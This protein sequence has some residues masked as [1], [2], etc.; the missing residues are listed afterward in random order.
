[1]LRLAGLCVVL[2]SSIVAAEEKEPPHPINAAYA[3]CIDKSPSTAGMMAC[4]GEAETAWDGELNAAYRELVGELK[5]KPLEALKQAQRAWVAQRDK[6]YALQETIR[7]QLQGTM[8]GP[9]LSDQRVTL[10]KSRTLQ[11]RAYKSFL[12]DGR[13]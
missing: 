3:A 9:V 11:L 5:V 6:E 2:G 13:P 1:M 8:W 7:E 10:V 12:D 4:S